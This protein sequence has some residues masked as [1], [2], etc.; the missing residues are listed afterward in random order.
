MRKFLLMLCV[1]MGAATLALAA[2]SS[3]ETNAGYVIKHNGVVVNVETGEAVTGALP[4]DA[5]VS[6]EDAGN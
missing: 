3:N 2:D 5:V 6:I 1:C 4:T